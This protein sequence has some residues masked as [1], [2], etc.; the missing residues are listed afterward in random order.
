MDECSIFL[1]G[2]N[3]EELI[4]EGLEQLGKTE[5]EVDVKVLNKGKSLGPASG[6]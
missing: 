4:A 3:L 5:D 2:K 1:E 6:Y